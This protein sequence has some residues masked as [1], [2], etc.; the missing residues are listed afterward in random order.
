VLEF[1]LVGGDSMKIYVKGKFKPKCL[2][3]DREA[4]LHAIS[5]LKEEIMLEFVTEEAEE[6]Y[7]VTQ[8]VITR[9]ESAWRQEI[10]GGITVNKGQKLTL[11]IGIKG[12]ELQG[13]LMMLGYED[14]T[15]IQKK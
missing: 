2:V 13:L 4:K 12:K 14:E 3:G 11:R 1:I 10:W 9:G 15:K 8:A 7:Q 5:F 6:D